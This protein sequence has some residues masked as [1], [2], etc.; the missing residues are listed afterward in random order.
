MPAPETITSIEFRNFKAFGQFSVGLQ[1]MNILVGPNNSGKST[2]LSALR[3]LAEALRKPRSKS[4]ERV[5]GP[6]GD[7]LGYRIAGD[8]IPISLENVHTDY[9]ETDTRVTFRLSNRNSLELYFPEDGGCLLLADTTGK[10]V[11]TPAEFKRAFPITIGVVPVLGPLEHEEELRAEDTV[12]RGLTT[13]LASRH[14]RNYWYHNPTGFERFSELIRK[15][16]PGM[17]ILRPERADKFSSKLVMFAEEN[18]MS[19]ELFWAG[20]GFQVWCQL[21]THV[22]RAADD[23]LLVVD[24]PEIYLHPDVQRQFLSILRDVGP[25]VVLATHS[26]EIMGEA[27]PAEILLIDKARRA[28]QRLR[29][30]QGVQAVMD[31]IGS[32]QNITLTRLA[33][34]RRVLFVEGA[35]DFKILRRFALQLGMDDLAAGNDITAVESGGF[36]SWERIKATAWGIEKTM[37][38]A[39][40][41]AA[42][43]D[44]D[45]FSPEEVEQI[46]ADLSEPLELAHIHTRKEMEN[47]LLVPSVLERAFKKVLA[48][49][50]RR[51]GEIPAFIESI[52]SI[53]ERITELTKSDLQGQYLAK[54]SEF[55]KG[56]PTDKAVLNSQT[57]QWF[58]EK[59]GALETRMEIVRGKDVLGALRNHLQDSYGVNL[60]DFR[61]VD[62]FRR[63]EVP[64]D[65][66]GFLEKLDEYRRS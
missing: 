20:F 44:R 3:A 12:R 1:H 48:D 31:S 23:T 27:D 33:R 59:W 52:R 46:L 32:I 15:S 28:A 10:P 11:G 63:D 2:V 5:T 35:F 18:R 58:D 16:W 4:A 17:D 22:S 40:R 60:T 56:S 39:L 66:R 19:R 49:R 38:A 47:Y 64:P 36:T 42:V 26:T 57:L 14:F 25:D 43:F 21:L 41:I 61:I 55:L 45:F 65:L 54:R 50:T 6:G 29:D 30:V 7:R 62:E 8:S 24:E 51:G 34:N 13:H 37:G 9:N 53:L